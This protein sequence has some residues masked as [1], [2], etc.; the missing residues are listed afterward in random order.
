[1][2]VRMGGWVGIRG[3][4]I[5]REIGMYAGKS[6][7]GHDTS[8]SFTHHSSSVNAHKCIDDRRSESV[9]SYGTGAT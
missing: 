3:G 9:V 8:M 5:E 4:Y 2:C 1:M 7:S 6:G